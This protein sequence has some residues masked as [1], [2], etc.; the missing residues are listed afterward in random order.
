MR[1]FCC[2]AY[3]GSSLRAPRRAGCAVNIALIYVIG[4]RLCIGGWAGGAA[5][6]AGANR[7]S[8][9]PRKRSAQAGWPAGWPASTPFQ[10]V[11]RVVIA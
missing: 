7:G 9:W 4:T 8:G 10:C 1:L 2:D 11:L 3:C 6:L 5:V